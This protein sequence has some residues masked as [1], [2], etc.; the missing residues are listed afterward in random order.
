MHRSLMHR[1]IFFHGCSAIVDPTVSIYTRTYIKFGDHACGMH[2]TLCYKHG[3]GCLGHAPPLGFD[4]FS[5][6]PI[7]SCFL[8]C[9]AA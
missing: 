1:N 4:S 8:G 6:N 3:A 9:I 7:K 5:Q 2:K